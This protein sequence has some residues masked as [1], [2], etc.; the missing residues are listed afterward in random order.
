MSQVDVSVETE[1]AAA[2]AD[3]AAVMFD[4]ARDPEWM[5]A[6]TGVDVIDPALKP[7]ARVVRRGTF[8][9]RTISWAT[10]VE[11]VH[12][13]HLLTLQVTDGPFVGTV[14]YSIQRT[15]TGSHV[16]IRSVGEPSSFKFLPAALVTGPMRTALVADLERLKALVERPAAG[17]ARA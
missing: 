4:P 6:V 16:R 15:A 2:P 11:T 3:V 13:P 9:G 8:L 5:Q 7:G 10:A 1:I 12:F 17:S 14:Q